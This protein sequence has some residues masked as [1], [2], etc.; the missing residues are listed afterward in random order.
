MWLSSPG[1]GGT[2]PGFC[3]RGEKRSH[4]PGPLA[5]GFQP[6]LG[7]EVRGS[8]SHF[9]RVMLVGGTGGGPLASLRGGAREKVTGHTHVT[10]GLPEHEM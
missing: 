6:V 5:T 1:G 4:V 9:G 2:I 3:G 8:R 10:G 7:Q